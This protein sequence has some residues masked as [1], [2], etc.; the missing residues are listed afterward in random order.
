[1][2]VMLDLM[3]LK[4]VYK[5]LTGIDKLFFISCMCAAD[6]KRVSILCGGFEGA[7]HGCGSSTWNRDS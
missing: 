5:I 6:R 2:R 3:S 1:M 4:V 7:S